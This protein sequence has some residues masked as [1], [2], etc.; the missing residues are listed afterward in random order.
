ALTSCHDDPE[1]TPAAAVVT[2]PAYFNLSDES[3]IDL[4]DTSSDFV[5]HLYR[6]NADGAL[7]VPVTTTVTAPQ[8][9]NTQIFTIPTEV[10]FADGV[11]M[12][13][14][15]VT[16]D[17]ADITPLTSYMFDLKVD[18]ESTP[19]F[20]TDVTYDVSYVPWET[21]TSKTGSTESE[22]SMVGLLTRP[23]SLKCVVQRHPAQDGFY[24][25]LH[26]Y[27]TAP[28]LYASD[29]E[30]IESEQRYPESDPNYLYIN[31]N[32]ARSV[33]F[34]NSKGKAQVFYYTGYVLDK[35]VPNYGEE[36]MLFCEFSAYLAK[37]FTFPGLDGTF[38]AQDEYNT[39]AGSMED[40]IINFGDKMSWTYPDAADAAKG[41]FGYGGFDSWQLIL[42][43]AEKPVEWETLGACD[44]VDGFIANVFESDDPIS[45]KVTVERN[46]ATPTR[47]RIVQPYLPGNYPVPGDPITAT[48]DQYNIEINV[49][50]PEMV[51]I[52][53]QSTGYVYNRINYQICN[54]GAWY[55]YGYAEGSTPMSAAEIKKQG[56]NDTFEN[57]V[58]T[59]AHPIA[60]YNN[61]GH[62]LWE[63]SPFNA[64]KLILPDAA[65]DAQSLVVKT[66]N[67]PK[68]R[69]QRIPV[70]VSLSP[71]KPV[72]YTKAQ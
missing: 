23:W 17:I 22:L 65:A 5:V 59:I 32:N 14:Y 35:N 69:S 60:I 63:V 31:A 24:R 25:V 71:V 49:K 61:E 42:A 58:I 40:G 12:A 67:K 39:K 47:Y 2:P 4:E 51:L 6:A 20:S 50:D 57:G 26:P 9:V 64:G 29:G 34:S 28:D 66:Q 1:Y 27:Y 70:R 54:A 44:Y 38:A 72:T 21:V 45:Y 15:T 55:Y 13:D 30:T 62:F 43:D 33:Y 46:I 68:L 53:V 36:L 18:G 3:V 19:Y 7:T 52:D 48:E 56:L 11:T 16:F 10:T 37:T 8:G 41:S